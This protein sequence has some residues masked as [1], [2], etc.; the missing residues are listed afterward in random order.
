MNKQIS[1]NIRN[2][3]ELIAHAIAPI[4]KKGALP[5][6]FFYL[7]SGTY[8]YKRR[9]AEFLR[10]MKRADYIYLNSYYLGLILSFFGR[11]GYE[12][13]NAED[14][15]NLLISKCREKKLRVFLLG[16]KPSTLKKAVS[17][18]KKAYPGVNLGGFEGYFKNNGSAI[19]KINDFKPDILI[20][21]LG[22]GYQEPWI[23]RNLNKFKRVR[24]IVT[25]GNFIDILGQDRRLT[26]RL[27]RKLEMEWLY[28]LMSEPGRLWKRYFFGF[29]IAVLETILPERPRSS[30]N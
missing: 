4:K 8:Y 24:S 6:V 25:V 16:A 29:L 11:G 26:P 10:A 22:S 18:I 19:R 9:S 5:S 7:N 20:V 27:L 28:R 21:G 15:F 17:G 13:I 30:R 12:K 14:F 1:V 2:R 23:D 3:Q